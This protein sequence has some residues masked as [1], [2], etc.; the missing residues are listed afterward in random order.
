[1]PSGRGPAGLGAFMRLAT[2]TAASLAAAGAGEPGGGGLRL[3]LF[4]SPFAGDDILQRN[5]N[6]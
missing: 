5:Y 2:V 4:V 1:M 3:P 6:Y